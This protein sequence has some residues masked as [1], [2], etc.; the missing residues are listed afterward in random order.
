M[1]HALMGCAASRVSPEVLKARATAHRVLQ[2][3]RPFIAKGRYRELR[4]QWAAVEDGF[5]RA[6][7]APDEFP[8]QKTVF[9]V[10][11]KKIVGASLD[12]FTRQQRADMGGIPHIVG[13]VTYLDEAARENQSLAT[14][15]MQ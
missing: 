8:F 6:C 5:A 1:W 3:W 7:A 2:R 15:P 12:M 10:G 11:F 14:S 9:I 4:A 13:A